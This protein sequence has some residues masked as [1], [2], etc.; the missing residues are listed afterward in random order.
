M[1]TRIRLV[2]A[3]AVAL[4]FLVSV[5]PAFSTVIHVPEDLP[6]IQAGVDVASSGDTVL[7]AA[8]TYYE[9]IEMKGDVN[10]RS[11]TGW[12]DCVTIDGG[13]W[14]FGGVVQFTNLS[15]SP[16]LEGFTITNG[17]HHGLEI[18]RTNAV[19]RNCLITENRTNTYG[20]GVYCHRGFPVFFDCVISENHAEL[21]GGGVIASYDPGLAMTDCRIIRNSSGS[22]SGGLSS[23]SSSIFTRCEFLEN[24]AVFS[25]GGLGL[26]GHEIFRDCRITG[27][28]ALSGGGGGIWCGGGQIFENCNIMDNSANWDGGGVFIYEDKSPIS[29]LEF[30]QCTISGNVSSGGD[31]GG[32]F[33]G[34]NPSFDQCRIWDNLAV[35]G[36]GGGFYNRGSLKLT[37]CLVTENSAGHNG[38][39][40]FCATSDSTLVTQCTFAGNAA[41]GQ[42]GGIYTYSSNLLL[43]RSIIAFS[44]DGE[45]IY[46]YGGNPPVGI[47]MCDIYGN[48]GG[49]QVCGTDIG[50]NFSED[51]LFCDIAT[52]N[53]F[54][55]QDSPCLI[56]ADPY[57]FVIGANGLGDC[58]V[59]PVDDPALARQAALGVLGQNHPNPFN[60]LTTI[61][62]ALS[63]P[64]RP[65]LRIFD[66]AGRQVRTLLQGERYDAGPG[67][68]TWNGRDDSGKVLPS[69]VYFYRLDVQDF[70]ETRRLVLMK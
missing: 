64:G 19:I 7:V 37:E 13:G 36:S 20:G 56:G 68:V 5:V 21:L 38:G 3:G 69:G 29:N 52:G 63:K 33:S 1:E 62:F 10:L 23:S 60:P 2:I 50:G 65:V 61:P 55:D 46:C 14:T 54:L 49:D 24:T 34:G 58:S 11:E 30:F 15:G 43:T 25:G 31:G 45:G 22:S 8:G 44:Q 48:E 47:G 4:S 6:S 27:N 17:G 40:A 32:I 26:G 39:G 57:I 51:P 28:R 18:Y 67:Q 59:A 66:I 9:I 53:Y 12:A 41:S 70:R 42:G 35:V 16:L